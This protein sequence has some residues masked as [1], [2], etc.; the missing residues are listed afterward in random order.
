MVALR[1]ELRLCLLELGLRRFV[2]GLAALEI[3]A[4]DEVLVTQPL[5]A[6]EVARSDIAIGRRCGHLGTRGIGGEL[7]ILW[8][9]LREHLAGVHMLAH[10]DLALG[11]LAADPKADARLDASPHLGGKL[12]LSVESRNADSRD[13]DRAQRLFWRSGMRAAGDG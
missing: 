8:I 6:L 4:A 2:S 11:D 7:E 1:R 3:G 12:R 5:V 13:L 10:V 9:E